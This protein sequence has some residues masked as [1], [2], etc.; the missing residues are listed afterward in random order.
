MIFSEDT[1]LLSLLDRYDDDLE[2]KD[3]VFTYCNRGAVS[4]SAQHRPSRDQPA[5]LGG[6]QMVTVEHTTASTDQSEIDQVST[7]NWRN[8]LPTATITLDVEP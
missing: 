2:L 4:S 3:A 1:I 5:S 8:L 7:I 6:F